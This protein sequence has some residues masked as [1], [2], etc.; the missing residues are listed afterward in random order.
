LLNIET[1]LH[2]FFFLV[3]HEAFALTKFYH[4]SISTLPH[5]ITL[6]I[7]ELYGEVVL[8]FVL[9]ILIQSPPHCAVLYCM[10]LLN[11]ILHNLMSYYI[12]LLQIT[13]SYRNI[14]SESFDT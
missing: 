1:L 13:D 12:T 3:V 2:F 9:P 10:T 11:I 7:H 8:F 14:F 5:L 4:F 6:Y